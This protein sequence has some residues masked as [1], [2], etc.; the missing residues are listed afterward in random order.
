MLDAPRDQRTTWP[1]HPAAELFPLLADDDA[2]AQQGYRTVTDDGPCEVEPSTLHGYWYVW[3]FETR[4]GDAVG[5]PRP[6]K[7]SALPDVLRFL[8]VPRD[9]RW[10]P[11]P[12]EP[13][14]E[15]R[16]FAPPRRD[17]DPA[18]SETRRVYLIQPVHGGLVKIGSAY[19]PTSRLDEIQ[20]MSP[21]PLQVVATIPGGYAVE[22]E[23]HQR[24]AD[25][26]SH[27]EWFRPSE[28]LFAA[29]GVTR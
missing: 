12:T 28:E 24:F 3:K 5:F 16:W 1:V 9:S 27:G 10:T 6:V 19:S 29:F 22:T 18:A 21:V 20:R 26:R 7:A 4:S 23:L 25:D 8:G 17:G 14:S 13:R 15:S 11:F 2:I